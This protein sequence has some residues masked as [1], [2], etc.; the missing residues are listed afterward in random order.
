[1]AIYRWKMVRSKSPGMNLG[2]PEA[3]ATFDAPDAA[4]VEI[5]TV[6]IH[7]TCPLLAVR[8]TG[9][10]CT[11]RHPN[12]SATAVLLKR[13]CAVVRIP[14]AAPPIRSPLARKFTS[15]KRSVAVT[16]CKRPA[17]CFCIAPARCGCVG[18]EV[19]AATA[20]RRA[21]R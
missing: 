13:D 10:A 2:R 21:V 4:R 12:E 3:L 16:P 11:K 6:E 20:L 18:L 19:P 7:F 9:D 15:R 14:A 1:M 5:K 17:A 8:A